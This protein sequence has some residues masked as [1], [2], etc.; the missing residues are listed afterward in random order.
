MISMKKSGL[1]SLS[2][3]FALLAGC[4]PAAGSP[5]PDPI[6][7]ESATALTPAPEPTPTSAPEP[8]P[9]PEPVDFTEFLAGVNAARKAVAAQEE[10]IDISAYTLDFHEQNHTFTEEEM[11]R[12]TTAHEPKADLTLEDVLDDVDT[13]FL[14]LQTTYGAYYYFGG[15]DVFLPIRDAVKEKLAAA[16]ASDPWDREDAPYLCEKLESILYKDLSPV[17]VD[18][19]FSIGRYAPRNTFAKYM[20]YVPDLYLDSMEGAENPDYLKPTIGPDGRICYWYAAL[21]HDGSDLPGTLDGNSLKWQQALRTSSNGDA[22]AF[23]ESEWEGIPVL[24]SRSMSTQGESAD[25][26]EQALQRLAGCG[27]E[28]A[29]SPLLIFDLRDNGGGSDQYI[30]GWFQDWAGTSNPTRGAATHRYSQLSCRIMGNDYYPAEYM[31]TWGRFYRRGT[32][33]ERSGPVF[34]LQ[35][36]G[37][38]SSGETAVEFFRMAADTLFVGGP[39]AGM[40]LV[41]N[42]LTLYLPHSGLSCYFGTGLIFCETDENR[43]GVGFLPDLWVDPTEAL[44]AVERL[45]EYYGLN[46]ATNEPPAM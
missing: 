15:D 39:T 10:S 30:M 20:Y 43:D 34:V 40:A 12:L 4:A 22:P 1:L 16:V 32:W 3:V 27:G 29:G 42:N 13:F 26:D 9:T 33:A 14:L 45:I 31:G 23:S 44:E 25:A 6:P 38:A 24:T 17:L 2:L 21:S 41:P 19:H 7:T 18:G 11:E 35:D 37:V 46:P 8:T 36:K 28:Y 5:A